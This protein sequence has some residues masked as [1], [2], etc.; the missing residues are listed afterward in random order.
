MSKPRVQSDGKKWLKKA[1][2]R[3]VHTLKKA[4]NLKKI[5]K[6]GPKSRH[7]H[8]EL[9]IVGSA[10]MK[11]INSKFLRKNY[12]TD[13]LSFPSGAPFYPKGLLGSLVICL[14]VLKRQ[15]RERKLTPEMELQILL[16]HGVLH[17]LGLDHEKSRRASLEMAKLEDLLLRATVPAAWIRK[18]EGEC[19]KGLTG[20]VFGLNL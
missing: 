20:R 7:W 15:A 5:S 2:L 10:K 17:L 13:V 18:T 19:L 14:P 4:K 8:V 11:K 3:L 16:A 12:A 9:E 1:Q 6:L